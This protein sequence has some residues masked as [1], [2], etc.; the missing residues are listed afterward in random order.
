MTA[1]N[2]T[3]LVIF[4]VVCSGREP[5][6]RALT[7]ARLWATIVAELQANGVDLGE[8]TPRLG[9]RRSCHHRTGGAPRRAAPRATGR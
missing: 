9:E 4:D 7:D 8:R 3:A 1:C 5:K 6:L 2:P